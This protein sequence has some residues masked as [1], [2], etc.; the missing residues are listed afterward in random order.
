MS[1]IAKANGSH[2]ER[3][4]HEL[5]PVQSDVR[6]DLLGAERLRSSAN[7]TAS[8]INDDPSATNN[9]RID[10]ANRTTIN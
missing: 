9:G 10:G 3:H 2:D 8:F 7:M 1:W 4:Q 6:R 5:E